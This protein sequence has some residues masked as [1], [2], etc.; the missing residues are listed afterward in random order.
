MVEPI[1]PPGARGWVGKGCALAPGPAAPRFA[2][3][4]G[5]RDGNMGCTDKSWPLIGRVSSVSG[6]AEPGASV[7]E[8]RQLERWLAV[9]ALCVHVLAFTFTYI[10]IHTE[11]EL[12]SR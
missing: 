8:A 9:F 4:A 12:E 6:T 2:F 11:T 3:P 7:V 5:M 10:S 1:F